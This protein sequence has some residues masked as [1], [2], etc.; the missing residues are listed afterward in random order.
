MSKLDEV[1]RVH[2]WG[3]TAA[4]TLG[5]FL[6]GFDSGVISGAVAALREE[7]DA[8]AA[9]SGW[10]VSSMLLGCGLGAL[11]AGRLADRWGKVTIMKVSAVLFVVSA[12]GSGIAT[13]SIEFVCY[14]VIGGLAV[15]AASVICPAYV[16]EIAPAC[17]R[18]QL[19]SMQQMAIVLG[20]FAA[21][22]CNYLL[23]VGA[24][25]AAA[26]W[27]G[28]YAAWQWMFWSELL[29][30]VIFG[31]VLFLIPE[32]PRYLVQRGRSA[33]AREVLVSILGPTEGTRT[34]EAI[35]ESLATASTAEQVA[36]NLGAMRR[37]RVLWIGVAL[38]LLQQLSGINIVFYYGPVMWQAAGFDESGAL[39]RTLFSGG[40][41]IACTIVAI[42]LVDRLGRRPMLLVGAAVMTLALAGVALA[43]GNAATGSDHA[44]VLSP[45]TGWAALILANL[46][47]AGFAIT[48]GPIV[49]VLLGEMFPAAIKG[50]ALSACGLAIWLANFAITMSFESLL[51]ALGLGWTYAIYAS[52]AGLS[53]YF[54]YRF[55]PETK[56][57]S[58]EEMET[59]FAR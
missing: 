52:F 26:S 28:G 25:G 35:R 9:Q 44:L 38:A 39:G 43:F 6:F 16:C 29:P 55:I 3:I 12:W 27:W 40:L 11:L 50:W 32:S 46:Y 24:G 14:R 8:S 1:S 47:V 53:I 49:W 22:L 15:G 58:L 36:Q 10:N 4:A 5:G 45:A 20:L 30:A 34:H 59:V 41:N 21:F 48:W 51:A 37:H 7:F 13:G 42:S 2:L 33:E 18:G 57:R 23:A 17:V 56:G 19:A 31:F 54:V